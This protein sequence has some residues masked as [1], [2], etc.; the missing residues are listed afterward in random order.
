[1]VSAGLKILRDGKV[2][3]DTIRLRILKVFIEEMLSI[4]KQDV[5]G[6]TIRQR[7]LKVGRDDYPHAVP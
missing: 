3:G 5:V 1:M 6:D 2:A 7:M 4:V